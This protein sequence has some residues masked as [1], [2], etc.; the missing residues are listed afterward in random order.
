MKVFTE[1]AEVQTTKKIETKKY[2]SYDG[3]LFSDEKKCKDYESAL[4]KANII[5]LTASSDCRIVNE[6][7]MYNGYAGSEEY[8]Y[9][10]A[11]VTEDT[12]TPLEIVHKAFNSDENAQ[13][14]FKDY[15][16]EGEKLVL[17]L[18]YLNCFLK[19]ETVSEFECFCSYGTVEEFKKRLAE[20]FSLLDL[21]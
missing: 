2:M 20:G 18:G 5:A 4:T 3:K 14:R 13:L 16:K 21:D 9:F 19:D 8:Y 7:D 11:K 17:G 6:F 12:K 1:V 15:L 10:V